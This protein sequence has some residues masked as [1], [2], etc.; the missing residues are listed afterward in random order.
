MFSLRFRS[1]RG[2]PIDS[3]HGVATVGLPS[4]RNIVFPWETFIATSW[5]HPM[6]SEARVW[7]GRLRIGFAFPSAGQLL[8][9]SLQ[10]MAG[11]SG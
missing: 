7:K 4:S 2:S 9:P 1:R 5:E 10:L 11:W 3:S 8:G 6:R